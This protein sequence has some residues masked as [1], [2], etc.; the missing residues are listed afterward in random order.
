M[1]ELNFQ[2]EDAQPL[3]NAASPHLA[4]RLRIAESGSGA[5]TEIQSVMLQCQIR[6]EPALRRYDREEQQGLFELFGEPQRWGESMR[7]MLW[8]H[9]AI[10]VPA[11]SGETAVDLPVPC[12]YDFNIAATKYFHGLNDGEVPLTLLFSGTIFYQQNG[13]LR[14]APIAWDKE[15]S[16]RMPVRVWRQ[17]MDYYYANVTWLG[18]RKDV[19]ERLYRYK[20]RLAA[21]T[22]E[23]ALNSLLE[24]VEEP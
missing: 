23:Q 18:L 21:P 9:C 5:P 19:F 13:S 8:T 4:F 14:I 12:T 17:M 22:W 1:P 6:I 24:K 10:T 3:A 20:S 16:F 2:V 11:F 7:G 15:A